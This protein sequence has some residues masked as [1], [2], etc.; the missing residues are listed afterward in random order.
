MVEEV[1]EPLSEDPYYDYYS[2]FVYELDGKEMVIT[3][4][5]E[6]EARILLTDPDVWGEEGERAV[7]VGERARRRKS[8]TSH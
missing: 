3:A 7:F 8:F 6:S 1:E 4:V 5:I 2:D